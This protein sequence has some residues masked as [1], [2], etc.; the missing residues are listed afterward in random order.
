MMARL[1]CLVTVLALA[2]NVAAADFGTPGGPEPANI[3]EI[4]GVLRRTRTTWNC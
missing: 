3:D 2:A 1:C 4:A